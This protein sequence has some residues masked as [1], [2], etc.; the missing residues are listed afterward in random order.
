MQPL[1]TYGEED[2]PPCSSGFPNLGTPEP[3]RPSDTMDTVYTAGVSIYMPPT[4]TGSHRPRLER[5][6]H[7]EVVRWP[8]MFE[9]DCI[10]IAH[11]RPPSKG[12]DHHLFPVISFYRMGL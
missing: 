12:E 2:V 6:N 9:P 3:P 1:C 11:T 8:N 4:L 7:P 5:L 10:I